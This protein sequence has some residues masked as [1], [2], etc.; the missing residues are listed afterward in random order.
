MSKYLTWLFSVIY[1]AEASEIKPILDEVQPMWGSSAC[2]ENICRSCS[3]WLR[4]Q[5]TYLV[6]PCCRDSHFFLLPTGTSLLPTDDSPFLALFKPIRCCFTM[7]RQPLAEWFSCSCGGDTRWLIM[8][9][10]VCECGCECVCVC[11]SVCRSV[12]VCVCV[13]W[14]TRSA[15]QVLVLFPIVHPASGSINRDDSWSFKAGGF[16]RWQ[17][18]IAKV[19]SITA[20][21]YYERR[22]QKET[23]YCLIDLQPNLKIFKESSK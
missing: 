6:D 7:A 1:D 17:A 10:I 2:D 5:S 16:R 18:R 13:K 12:C 19:T 22:V 9:V 4:K 14:A 15:R 3:N 23:T 20:H 11:L 8:I 21:H